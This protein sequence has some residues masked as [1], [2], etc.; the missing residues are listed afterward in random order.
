MIDIDD[1]VKHTQALNDIEQFFDT[2]KKLSK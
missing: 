2:L 1:I